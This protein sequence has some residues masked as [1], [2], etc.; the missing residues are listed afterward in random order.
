MEEC[1]RRL[2]P[3]MVP[4]RLLE[5]GRW[6]RISS[7]KIDRRALE[8]IAAEALRRNASESEAH[9]H[10]GA[11]STSAAEGADPRARAVAVLQRV[12]AEVLGEPPGSIDAERP[13]ASL[14]LTSLLAVH[15]WQ[16]ASDRGLPSLSVRAL[17]AAEGNV[18]SVAAAAAA[19]ASARMGGGEEASPVSGAWQKLLQL[20]TSG[21]SPSICA[22]QLGRPSQQPL[23]DPAMLFVCP[24]DGGAGIEGYRPLALQLSD[25]CSV[26]GFEG[27]LGPV[28]SDR[29]KQARQ[30][31]LEMS[32]FRC[33]EA[34][35]S[36]LGD[37][38]DN[39]V[40]GDKRQPFRLLGHSWGCMVALEMARQ[41]EDAGESV[42]CVVLL[43]PSPELF[44]TGPS[45]GT[46]QCS[47][48]EALED[49]FYSVAQS[50]LASR[51]LGGSSP[52]PRAETE[53]EE[54]GA[55]RAARAL[56]E[57]AREALGAEELE[58]LQR[59]ADARARN[60][61]L[62]P[63]RWPRFKKRLR[64]KVFLVLALGDQPASGEGN[65]SI[66]AQWEQVEKR[67]ALTLA[68]QEIAGDVS[69]LWADGGHFSMLAQPHV[70]ALARQL[71]LV[72]T[73]TDSFSGLRESNGDEEPGG[74]RWFSC[75]GARRQC[76][77]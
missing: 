10:D 70:E 54:E 24:G 16:L 3:S 42:A 68:L 32:V 53:T 14:G 77:Q 50:A 1:L 62:R 40:D 57:A 73:Q 58:L 17:L 43:D 55:S 28:D 36:V 29:S 8:D 75:A 15:A 63:T 26:W 71:A 51:L 67:A 18:A 6:P 34:A 45:A 76:M 2:S 27:L 11:G 13:V 25:H 44:E 61:R 59:V 9:G 33:M 64:A 19:A 66:R 56:V 52:A 72:T 38:G 35:R 46:T 12:L 47:G 30:E 60:L 21:C 69:T 7:G 48:Q 65:T 5:V 20:L 37:G 74:R 23:A 4:W 49:M 31:P 39:G 22:K 41:L